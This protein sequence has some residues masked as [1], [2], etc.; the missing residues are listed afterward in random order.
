MSN[1]FIDKSP[2]TRE[3]TA[4]HAIYIALAKAGKPLLMAE[5][6]KRAK[7]SFQKTETLVRAYM[8]PFHNAP[9]RRA[10]IAIVSGKEGYKL[11]T[12]KSE[13]KAIRPPRG[14]STK[15]KA[16][17]KSKKAPPKTSPAKARVSKDTLPAVLL[18]A[19]SINEPSEN[20]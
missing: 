15:T 10:G 18:P 3:G 16:K 20:K 17:S 13:P 5:I 6:S 9:M 14:E 4:S 2:F 1:K 11:E 19:I 7:V 8:N 12:C